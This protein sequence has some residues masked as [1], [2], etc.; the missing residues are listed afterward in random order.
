MV[1]M[2]AGRIITKAE[3]CTA[4]EV[5]PESRPEKLA[6]LSFFVM[7]WSCP[8]HQTSTSRRVL[9]YPYTHSAE[10]LIMLVKFAE[11]SFPNSE[12]KKHTS[13]RSYGVFCTASCEWM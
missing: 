6:A 7:A 4:V 2:I 11:E 10:Y 8:A 3:C 5:N 1:S 9:E 13:S 12:D